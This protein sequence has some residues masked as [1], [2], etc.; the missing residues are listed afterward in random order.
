MA[1]GYAWDI[2]TVTTLPINAVAFYG[3]VTAV[4]ATEILITSYTVPVG[5]TS[6]IRGVF[7]E[8][9]TD[10]LFILYLNSN[11]IWQWRNA[12]TERAIQ[13]P[14]EKTLV[15]GDIVELKVTNLKNTNHD[16][17]GGFYAYE[18]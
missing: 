16:F 10:G 15:V 13:S 8:G 4:P 11:P 3:S 12:W 7:G 17:T 6:T 14:L 9:G 1:Q 18:V 5:K 2:Q